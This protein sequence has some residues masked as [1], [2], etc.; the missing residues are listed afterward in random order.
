MYAKAASRLVGVA[1]GRVRPF[2][3]PDG[4]PFDVVFAC[5][6]GLEHRTTKERRTD[7]TTTVRTVAGHTLL[8]VDGLT[9]AEERA[10]TATTALRLAID[11][12][13]GQLT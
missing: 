13:D 8:F 9:E 3:G 11:W 7:A 10:Q 12:V 5:G 2:L 4:Y 1:V 6:E